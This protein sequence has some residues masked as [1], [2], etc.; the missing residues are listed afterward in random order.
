MGVGERD[1]VRSRWRVR[2][3]EG[4]TNRKLDQSQETKNFS[5][6]SY[7]TLYLLIVSF[8]CSMH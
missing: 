2:V 8:I 5:M 1:K 6:A 4:R 3:N 7:R